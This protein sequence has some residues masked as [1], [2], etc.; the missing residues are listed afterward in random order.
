M[1]DVHRDEP[2]GV[3]PGGDQHQPGGGAGHHPGRAGERAQVQ[4]LAVDDGGQHQRWHP[5]A[6]GDQGGQAV[7]A[8]R[9]HRVGDR[10]AQFLLG[11]HVA[12]GEDVQPGHHLPGCLGPEVAQSGQRPGDPE[13]AL[14]H[15]VGDG[16]G[17]YLLA[18]VDAA[19]Q[20]GAGHCRAETD[21]GG[22]LAALAA[23]RAVPVGQVDPLAG[24]LAGGGDV[25]ER[26]Q[27]GERIGGHPVT[28]ATGGPVSASARRESDAVGVARCTRRGYGAARRA[29]RGRA[30]AT[31]VRRD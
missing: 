29:M 22:D 24:L 13:R 6:A 17:A 25:G 23:Q 26:E 30:V 10:P 15:R 20:R 2:A 7:E 12:G 4:Q 1:T 9:D 16:P 3:E 14:E 31:G 27:R 18:V 5:G 28:L 11:H 8:G 21:L 19:L